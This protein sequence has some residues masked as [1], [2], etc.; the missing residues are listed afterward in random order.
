MKM[1][2]FYKVFLFT[3]VLLFVAMGQIASA[4]DADI[5]FKDEFNEGA[6]EWN[7]TSGKWEVVSGEYAQNDNTKGAAAE[8]YA[9]D[10]DWIDYTYEADVKVTGGYDAD[11]LFRVNMDTEYYTLAIRSN[12]FEGDNH[13]ELMKLQKW[14]WTVLGGAKRSI[15][16][17]T[18]YHVKI[19]VKGNNVKVIFNNEETPAID[20]TDDN[21]I[22]SGKIGLKTWES[23]A[24]FDNVVVSKLSGSKEA[25]AAAGKTGEAASDKS[26]EQKAV[27]NPKTGDSGIS[28]YVALG[29]ISGVLIL[30]AIRGMRK[31]GNQAS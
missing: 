31:G 26:V 23:T 20:F 17:N 15:E 10:F 3:A 25:P 12:S 18:L 30:W 27:V 22:V 1:K 2:A 5:L 8:T 14:N 9:G 21:P 28:L 16:D 13:L 19:A 7:A 24:S 29:V 11:M 6:K 4:A